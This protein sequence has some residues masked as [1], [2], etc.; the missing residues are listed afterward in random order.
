[1]RTP[2]D[3]AGIATAVRAAVREVDPALAVF[4]VETL[5][6]TVARSVSERRF[7]MLLVVVFAAAA[8]ALA[9]VGLHGVLS[10][11]VAQ[12][13]REIGIRIALGA[14]PAAV[15]GHVVREGLGLML[16]GLAIG[17]AGAVVAGRLM[18]SLLFEVAP[19][20]PAI[21]ASVALLL[22]VVSLAASYLPA[23][24]AARVDPIVALRYE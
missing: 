4:G 12:R 5:D 6:R 2:G 8:L 13:T 23:R 1:V 11:T 20:D 16:A 3:P 19:A 10:V 18:S 14:K 22:A 21:F 7:T 17:L 15:V 9:A 24:R